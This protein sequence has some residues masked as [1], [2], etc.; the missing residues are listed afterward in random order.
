MPR[1]KDIYLVARYLRVPRDP[2][3]TSKK[4]YV[5]DDKNISYTES[6]ALTRGLKNRDITANIILNLTQ[7]RVEKCNF[8]TNNGWEELAAYYAKA[9]P[10]Y[11]KLIQSEPETDE[12]E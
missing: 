2:T 8:E 5:K 12:I 6:V 7:K 1:E 4:G 9:Y 3:Q 11:M 10:Q